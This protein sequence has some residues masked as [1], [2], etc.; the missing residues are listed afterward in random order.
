[1]SMLAC[2]PP[3]VLTVPSALDQIARQ[4]AAAD[5]G[6]RNLSGDMALLGQS[7]ALGKLS[8]PGVDPRARVALLRRIGRASLSVGRLAE[9]HMNALR[10]IEV[11]GTPEQQRRHMAAAGFG[12]IFGVWGA[13]GSQPVRITGAE[14][15]QLQ[16]TGSKRFASGLGTVGTVVLTAPSPAGTRLLIA[17]VTDRARA[18]NSVWDTSGMRATA[19]GCYDFDGVI[20][21]PLG[22][23]GDYQCEPHFHGGVWRYAAV[24]VGGL[25]ALAEQVRQVITG[26]G[27]AA[28]QVQLHRLARLA[29]LAHCARLVVEDAAIQAEADAAGDEAVSLSLAAREAVEQACLEGIALA[30]RALG[31]RSFATGQT[32]ERVRRDLA[33]FLRQADLDG[34]L[35]QVGETLCRSRLP[36]G[37]V[38]SSP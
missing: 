3:V 9:G 34:K 7:G 27:D 16:L 22:Q 37:E 25:E 23:P 1:M 21:E 10:L 35:Q 6:L 17:D 11:Y 5:A 20:A 4:A 14:G 12:Q 30:D 19:S 36:I 2:K 8:R 32:A 18:D 29:T 24:Q 38:W 28:T 31:A 33:F 13:D 26:F 15:D